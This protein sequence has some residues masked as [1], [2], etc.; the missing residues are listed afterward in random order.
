[1]GPG[2]GSAD[3]KLVVGML[4]DKLEHPQVAFQKLLTG[5]VEVHAL[6]F[7]PDGTVE[8]GKGVPGV[9]FFGDARDAALSGTH[10]VPFRHQM[11]SFVQMGQ[12]IPDIP[13]AIIES[14]LDDLPGRAEVI[15]KGDEILIFQSRGSQ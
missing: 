14:E 3:E 8:L 10:A 2:I 5:G 11:M 6:V 12:D 4:L 9:A 7:L 15:H 1:M 13:I